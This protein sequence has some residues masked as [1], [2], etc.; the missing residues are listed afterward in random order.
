MNY[1]FKTTIPIVN[2]SIY[3]FI[4]SET[5]LVIKSFS[6][7]STNSV[8][9]VLA[10]IYCLFPIGLWFMRLWSRDSS[11][12][13]EKL[14]VLASVSTS[15]VMPDTDRV[16]DWKPSVVI[17]SSYLIVYLFVWSGVCYQMFSIDFDLWSSEGET[18]PL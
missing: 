17:L 8:W 14:R 11:T 6:R 7:E 1:Y 13:G 18:R 15:A 10:K 3:W 5:A 4:G 9:F 16:C 2:F 12:L